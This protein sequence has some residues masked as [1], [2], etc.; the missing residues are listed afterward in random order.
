MK[1]SSERIL[2]SHVGSLAR[3][4]SLIPL[5]RLKEQGQSYDRDEFARRLREAVTDVVRQQVEAGIDIVTD[6][7]QGKSS[8]YGYV[9]ERFSGFERKPP[10]PGNEMRPRS[11][12]REYLAFPD[13]YA[14]SERIAEPFGGRGGRGRGVDTCTGPVSYKG[15][16]AVQA[17]IANLKAATK[18]R[19]IEDVF[20]PAISSAYVAATFANEYYRSPA[21]Y[22]KAVSDAMREEY[23]AIVDAGFILQIDDPRLVTY[24][25]MHPELS[26][27]D[28]RKWAAERVEVINDSLRG[29]PS[30]KVRFHTCYSIDVGPRIHE[31]ALKDI[32]DIILQINAG[33]YSFEAANPRHEHEYHV[34]ER[35]KLPA[36][37]ILMPGVISHTTNLVEHPE[38]IAERI[39]R[40]A[41]IVGRENVIAAADCGFAASALRFNDTHPSVA[42]LKFAALAEGAG[43]ATR[44]LWN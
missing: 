10:A 34:F 27:A 44:E 23:K 22:E 33:A 14:W 32:V 36:G 17:D 43:L 35:V 9:V 37:K 6:G 19:T 40:F 15:H 21:E 13:Y 26:V 7:E 8:F 30:E 31:M 5:L 18:G 29:M 1:R 24:F 3:A 39:V 12:G 25:M 28:C 4:D 11:A 2:T 16:A 38:L 42:W 41:K 20:M